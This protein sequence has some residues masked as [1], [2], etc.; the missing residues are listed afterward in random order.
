[1]VKPVDQISIG[2]A[3][4]SAIIND[5]M[6]KAEFIESCINVPLQHNILPPVQ[7]APWPFQNASWEV[8]KLYCMIVVPKELYNLSEN[9]SFYQSLKDKDVFRGFTIHKERKSFNDS[10]IYHLNSA[11]L[12]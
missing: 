3:V 6:N 9:D 10:P 7:D 2:C 12:I 8:Y 1:M 11:T 4:N 5:A